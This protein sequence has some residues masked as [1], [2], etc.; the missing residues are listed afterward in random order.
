MH[1][2]MKTTTK[3]L[4]VVLGLCWLAHATPAAAEPPDPP[5]DQKKVPKAEPAPQ[6][7]QE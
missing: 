1:T 6:R 3:A 4:V 2:M 7:P 5:P